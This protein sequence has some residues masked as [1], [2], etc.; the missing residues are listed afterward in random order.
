MII[1]LPSIVFGPKSAV[2]DAVQ[3]PFG[4]LEQGIFV[5]HDDDTNVYYD[6]DTTKVE[7]DE[8]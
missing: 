3:T 8:N 5:C 4:S 1:T 6:D 7:Y 2:L